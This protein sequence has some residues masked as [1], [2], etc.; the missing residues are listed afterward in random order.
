MERYQT[1]DELQ[2]ATDAPV[3]MTDNQGFVI[4]V[5]ACFT[6]VFGWSAEEITGQNITVI[7]PNGFHAPHHLGFSRFLATEKSTILNH[8]IQLRGI[9]KDG[10]E[11][12]AEHFIVAEQHQGKWIFA[13]TL[14]PLNSNG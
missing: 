13:A 1:I 9:T 5:N 12:E 2:L 11:I 8:P 3:V 6:A 7:I 10:R 14:N 4:Y